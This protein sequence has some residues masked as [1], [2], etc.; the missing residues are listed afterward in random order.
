MQ[1]RIRA[2]QVDKEKL[3]NCSANCI[4]LF[5][6]STHPASVLCNI[7]TGEL[8]DGKC[9][10]HNAFEI[11]EKQMNSFQS[12]FPESF[13]GK[14]SMKVFT[15]IAYKVKKKAVTPLDLYNTE[16]FSLVMYLLSIEKISYDTVFNYELLSQIPISMFQETGEARYTKGKSDLMNR[17]KVDVSRR[18]L[19]PDAIVIDGSG[20]LHSAIY[21][22]SNGPVQ[23]LVDETYL[24]KLSSFADIYIIF[25]RYYSFSIKSDTRSERIGSMKRNFSLTLDGPPPAKEMSL[26]SNT[27]KE[28]LTKII[29]EALLS[30]FCEEKMKRKILFT[31]KDECPEEVEM[32]T[33]TKHMDLKTTYDEADYIIPHP[34]LMARYALRSCLLT[35]MS[36]F[37]SVIYIKRKG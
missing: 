36:L 26:S 34:Q 23:D 7:Y 8:I 20:M 11:S 14:L 21:W 3:R 28:C 35:Q 29:S 13:R 1:G 16:M 9:N 2:D 30:K 27:T 17:L 25:D 33:R 6:V 5:M 18:N 19:K 15:M 37:C 31:A 32:G 10:V 24:K 4:H 12:G 22:Q